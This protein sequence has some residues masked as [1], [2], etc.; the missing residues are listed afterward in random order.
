[1]VARDNKVSFARLTLQIERQ[2]W[3]ST[4]SGCRVRVYE[5]LNGTLSLGEAEINF[6]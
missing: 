5:H 6:D 1:V 4:L 2:R 3:R